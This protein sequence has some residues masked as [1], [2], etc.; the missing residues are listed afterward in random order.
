MRRP[1]VSPRPNINAYF[2]SLVA[3][4][5]LNSGWGAGASS[6]DYPNYASHHEKLRQASFD[7]LLDGG[8]I[9]VGTPADIREQIASYHDSVG[10]FDTASLQVNFHQVTL[11]EAAS[12]IRLFSRMVMPRVPQ[13]AAPA[14]PFPSLEGRLLSCLFIPPPLDFGDTESEPRLLLPVARQ[15]L[16]LT[17]GPK[18]IS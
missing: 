9:W 14:R 3:A 17:P 4:V 12:S 2:K 6:G 5:E 15:R 1:I 13:L 18:R 16:P 11:D 7:T 8:T 10:G